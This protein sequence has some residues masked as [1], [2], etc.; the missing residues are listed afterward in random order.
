MEVKRIGIVGLYAAA[1]LVIGFVFLPLIPVVRAL[2][3]ARDS[4]VGVALFGFMPI[5]I[6]VAGV[7]WPRLVV[8][9]LGLF[10][11]LLTWSLGYMI[12]C[13]I[14]GFDLSSVG[15]SLSIMAPIM[16]PAYIALALLSFG[17]GR[18]RRAQA[19]NG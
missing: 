16:V 19:R 11:A 17:V 6:V 2:G 4:S 12:A 10:V 8:N 7:L 3:F 14:M 9:L 13:M 1:G 18:L 5:L 15:F